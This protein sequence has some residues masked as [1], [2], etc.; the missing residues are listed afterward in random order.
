M[1][2]SQD[3]DTCDLFYSE[4]RDILR[5][6]ALVLMGD[7]QMSAGNIIQ[8]TQMKHVEDN[9]LVQAL[10]ELTRKGA[11]LDSLFVNR[12]GLMGRVVIGGYVGDSARK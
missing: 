6:T 2:I 7:S 4:L 10:R 9:F 5:S 12:E 8:Q 1:T 3:D 11:L